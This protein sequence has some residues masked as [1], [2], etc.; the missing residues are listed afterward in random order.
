[1]LSLEKRVIRKIASV[2]SP[3]FQLIKANLIRKAKMNIKNGNLFLIFYPSQ[4]LLFYNF[5]NNLPLIIVNIV[6]SF[7]IQ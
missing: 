1:M 4:K 6:L 5:K 7:L 3:E 2:Y